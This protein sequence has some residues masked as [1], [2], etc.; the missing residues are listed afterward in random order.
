MMNIGELSLRL[1]LLTIDQANA[2]SK[3]VILKENE[4]NILDFAF[5]QTN[6]GDNGRF[7]NTGNLVTS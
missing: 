2:P 5:I 7:I 1:K 6:P 3:E 4:I